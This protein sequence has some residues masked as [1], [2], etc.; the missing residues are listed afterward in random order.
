[1]KFLCPQ[2]KAKYKIADTKVA[3]RATPRMKCRKCRLGVNL[4]LLD[5]VDIGKVN[6]LFIL[7]QPAH[8]QR[9]EKR[10]VA[11]PADRDAM[12]ASFIRRRLGLS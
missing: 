10:D 2:C 1:M 12:R 7:T 3:N 5:N 4:G 8:L 11:D 9:L 6:E